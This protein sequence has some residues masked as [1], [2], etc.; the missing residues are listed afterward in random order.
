M[1]KTI[2][3]GADCTNI[4]QFSEICP[5]DNANS[6][7]ILVDECTEATKCEYMCI[8][9]REREGNTCV[10][11]QPRTPEPGRPVS[12]R[13]LSNPASIETGGGSRTSEI[14]A[15]FLNNAGNLLPF[16]GTI[17]FTT[18]L[19]NLLQTSCTPR[20]NQSSCGVMLQSADT[21]GIAKVT[22]TWGNISNNANVVFTSPA[23]DTTPPS[24]LNPQPLETVTSLPMTLSV[25]TDES[26]RCRY[27]RTPGTAYGSMQSTTPLG[28]A[29]Q[30]TLDGLTKPAGHAAQHLPEQPVHTGERRLD[31]GDNSGIHEQRRPGA[32]HCKDGYVY[33]DCRHPPAEFMLNHRGTDNMLGH[34][35]VINDARHRLSQGRVRK[36]V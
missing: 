30:W 10:L 5:G 20:E 36:F 28:R 35:Q 25:Q 29:H 1:P 4:P 21:A 15:T 13:V 17:T 12:L 6:P 32:G 22:A 11:P 24:V 9:G 23:T 26:A 7:S 16:S 2:T 14:T 34:T 19:G 27:S 8:T 3:T 18:N 33:D 31:I